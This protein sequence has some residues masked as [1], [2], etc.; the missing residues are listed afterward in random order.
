MMHSQAPRARSRV[1]TLLYV[2]YLLRGGAVFLMLREAYPFIS[3]ISR[4]WSVSRPHRS[5]GISLCPRDAVPLEG[6]PS[7]QYLPMKCWFH[8]SPMSLLSSDVTFCLVGSKKSL[9]VSHDSRTILIAHHGMLDLLC[10][11]AVSLLSGHSLALGS[12]GSKPVS[13]LE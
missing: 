4:D 12:G 5:V 10:S 3:Y 8:P 13:L 9:R 11:I 6:C 7:W 2:S 1:W